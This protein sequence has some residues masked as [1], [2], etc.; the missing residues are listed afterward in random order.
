[1]EPV[2]SAVIA[3]PTAV[4]GALAE[5][6][7]ALAPRAKDLAEMRQSL[8]EMRQALDQ[9]ETP[10]APEAPETPETPEPLLACKDADAK[11]P[12]APTPPAEPIE[13]QNA[14]PGWL[15]SNL[16]GRFDASEWERLSQAGVGPSYIQNLERGGYTDLS[17]DEWSTSPSTVSPR[18]MPSRCGR[19]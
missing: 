7:E 16:A 2:R 18:R 1:V 10:E 15:P 8:E 17:V 14:P 5:V 9:A 6:R 19:A 4:A 3:T 13:V 12:I 11:A